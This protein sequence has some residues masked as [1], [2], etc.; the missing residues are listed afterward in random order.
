R[1]DEQPFLSLLMTSEIKRTRRSLGTAK[2]SPW[3]G[4][5]SES[6]SVDL[7]ENE[8][9][10]VIR[11]LV[12]P[13]AK[14]EGERHQGSVGRPEQ[15]S[16]RTRGEREERMTDTSYKNRKQPKLKEEFITAR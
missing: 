2:G 10:Q 15:N 8:V 3:V 13:H 5:L 9:E 14:R 4:S 6:V 11:L 7:K 1:T 12:P 16:K